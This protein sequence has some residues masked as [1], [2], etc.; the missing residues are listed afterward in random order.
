M[1]IGIN[2]NPG[3][4]GYTPVWNQEIRLTGINCHATDDGKKTPFD[5]AAAL[6]GSGRVKTEG[7]VTH[8]FPMERSRDAVDTFAA[9]GRS[10]AQSSGAPHRNIPSS[11]WE[12]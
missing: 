1:I 8:R 11:Q 6:I 7:M 5:I 4:I 12:A 9:G 2:F 3:H 10:P